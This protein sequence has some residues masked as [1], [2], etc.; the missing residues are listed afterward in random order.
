VQASLETIRIRKEYPG[1]VALDDVSV[2]FEGGRVSALLGKNG[3]GKSTLVKILA[4]TTEPTRGQILVNG[5]PVKLK[6][7]SDAFRLGLATVYQE[8]SLIPEL[9]VAENILLGRMPR[10]RGLAG[11][12]IDWPAARRRAREILGEIGVDLDVRQPVRRLGVARQ[13][14]IEIAKAMSFAPAAL[15]LDEPTSAL[16]RDETEKLFEIV[17]RLAARGVAVVYIT[18]RLQELTQVADTVTVLRDA[19]HV[20]TVNLAD[21]GPDEVIRMIFGSVVQKR[22]PESIAAGG[23]PL[24]EVRGLS[25]RDK[26][27]DINLTVHRGEI[28][29]IAGMI[30]S[31]RTELLRAIFGADSFDSGR[32]TLGGQEARHASPRAMKRLG[33]ALVPENRK[34]QALVLRLSI[35]TNLC[36]ASLK[37][38]GRRG[39]ITGRAEQAIAANFGRALAI[40]FTDARSPVN[41]LSGGNQQKVVLGKWLNTRPQL[42]LYDEPTRGIDLQ[43]KQQIFQI[44]WNLSRE[45]IGS[46]FVSSELEELL[47]VCH[48]ILIMRN[49]AI[50]D[51]VR[52]EG[53][54]IEQ[55]VSRCM[56]EDPFGKQR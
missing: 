13:Q 20:G 54:T 53:I 8:L 41:S 5:L 6:S 30:G 25:R 15:L 14:I 32:I 56:G 23:Q 36:L 45:G 17:R 31:G 26:F 33:A 34:E 51:E 44:I 4:G 38:V 55:L 10:K 1:V 50:V 28:L 27:H 52:P 19:R 43:A 21:A 35:R 11:W 48:R 12:M 3:A 22:R 29:G 16:A 39:L 7:A 46:I 9:T 49:G 40:K 37:S 2:R 42:M 18:H 24:L 47:E